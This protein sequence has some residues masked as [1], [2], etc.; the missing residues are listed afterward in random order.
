MLRRVLVLSL[1]VGAACNKPT[2]WIYVSHNGTTSL[3]AFSAIEHVP[4]GI[5]QLVMRSAIPV[6]VGVGS[7]S[8]VRVV[9][10]RLYGAGSNGVLQAFA[11][12]RS[13][14]DL[15]PTQTA[16]IGGPPHAMTSSANAL[17]VVSFGSNDVR[18]IG[19]DMAANL[20][21]LQ[22]TPMDTPRALTVSTDATQ[23]YVGSAGSSTTGPRVCAHAIATDGTFAPTPAGCISV[24]GEVGAMVHHADVLFV[25]QR[26]PSALGPNAPTNWLSAYSTA[27]APGTLALRGQPVDLGAANAGNIAVSVDG[28]F[29]F[30][31]RQGGFMTLSTADPMPV[32]IPVVP[33]TN[34]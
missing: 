21:S 2:P 13:N 6:P 14:G 31:P 11:I 19:I 26:G 29:L 7:V 18:A 12:E 16:P 33:I 22:T 5:P 10:D 27:G 25:M 23:L 34:S 17:F 9:G 24:A 20:T 32:V 15:T 4:S 3:S 8:A 28:R 1:L 30:V